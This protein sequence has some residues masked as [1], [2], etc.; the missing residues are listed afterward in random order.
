[1]V[2]C[3]WWV[4][5]SYPISASFVTNSPRLSKWTALLVAS[6]S[7]CWS[8]PEPLGRPCGTRGRSGY[9]NEGAA[10]V[11]G[12]EKVPYLSK[13]CGREHMYLMVPFLCSN[14]ACD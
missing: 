3:R 4:L 10:V 8:N 1:M 6:W 11:N 13:V 9:R 2:S 5:R 14:E 12:G 7:C